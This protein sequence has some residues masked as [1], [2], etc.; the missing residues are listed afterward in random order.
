MMYKAKVDVMRSVHNTQRK[1]S[2]FRIFDCQTWWYVKKHLGFKRLNNQAVYSD[3][4]NQPP[5]PLSLILPCSHLFVFSF[6]SIHAAV[7][8]F[9]HK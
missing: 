1:A 6:D 5:T 4:V 3:C 9:I 2:T 7:Y 8:M